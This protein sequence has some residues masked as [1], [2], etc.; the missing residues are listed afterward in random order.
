MQQA[1]WSSAA[2][3][4]AGTR[5]GMAGWLRALPSAMKLAETLRLKCA[6]MGI[7]TSG[8]AAVLFDRIKMHENKKSSKVSRKS[9][10]SKTAGGVVK[11]KKTSAFK[12]D[13]L[14]ASYYFHEVCGG[15]ISRCTPQI[16]PEKDGRRKLKEIKLVNGKF[17]KHPKWVLVK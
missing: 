14:S 11:P 15:K 9:L 5:I 17:G 13:R 3:S 4:G 1:S 6:K 2:S 10:S 16:I 7:G 8:T 12:G